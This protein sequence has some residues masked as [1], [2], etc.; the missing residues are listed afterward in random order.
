MKAVMHY[1]AVNYFLVI[2]LRKVE[3]WLIICLA[4][5]VKGLGQEVQPLAGKCCWCMWWLQP[6]ASALSAS[7]KAGRSLHGL[8]GE[9]AN[10]EPCWKKELSYYTD[11][12]H[13]TRMQQ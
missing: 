13:S 6:P 1:F 3:R 12:L 10:G 9:L 11:L 4:L 7:K 5:V 8:Q 2:G